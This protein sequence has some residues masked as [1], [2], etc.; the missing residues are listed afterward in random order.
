M[1]HRGVYDAIIYLGDPN[2]ISTWIGAALAQLRKTPVVF[3]GHGWKRP[4]AMV[5]KT[6]RRMFYSL[7][8]HFFVYASR[9]KRLGVMNGASP[10]RITVVYNSLDLDVADDVVRRIE[11]KG[12][13]DTRPGTVRPPGSP[14]ADMFGTDH[15]FMPVRPAAGCRGIAGEAPEGGEYTARG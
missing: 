10:E 9:S 15:A 3:W 7:A 12:L 2:V 6:L 5:K 13:N 4:E 1:R 11:A 8:D 14:V